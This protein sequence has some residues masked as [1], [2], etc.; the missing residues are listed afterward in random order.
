MTFKHRY[1][2]LP[3]HNSVT[4][5][6]LTQ[7]ICIQ[8]TAK[9]LFPQLLAIISLADRLNQGHVAIREVY[10]FQHTSLDVCCRIMDTV[11]PMTE[12]ERHS[13]RLIPPGY[14]V[15]FDTK[16]FDTTMSSFPLRRNDDMAATNPS[17]RHV[18]FHL[19]SRIV[20]ATDVNLFHGFLK[21]LAVPYAE[22]FTTN[23]AAIEIIECGDIRK[24]SWVLQQVRS[25]LPDLVNPNKARTDD[26]HLY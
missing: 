4:V 8:E 24:V 12:K 5:E 20:N 10:L 6:D 1:V 3:F 7:Y 15:T 26:E 11:F 23:A 16:L 2:V 25:L 18:V 19:P 22:A 21:K 9:D 13:N 14:R 17:Y